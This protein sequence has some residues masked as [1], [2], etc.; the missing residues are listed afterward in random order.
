MSENLIIDIADVITSLIEE[1]LIKKSDTIE[2]IASLVRTRSTKT[3]D[4][5]YISESDIKSAMKEYKEI[6]NKS[7]K[8]NT[9]TKPSEETLENQSQLQDKYNKQIQI[10]ILLT[11]LYKNGEFTLDQTMGNIYNLIKED[12]KELG[13]N[14][15]EAK[16]IIVSLFSEL[17]NDESN[18][19]SKYESAQEE[20]DDEQEDK[21]DEEEGKKKAS[22]SISKI[23]KMANIEMRLKYSGMGSLTEKEKK[24]K[25]TKRKTKNS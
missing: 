19:L 8:N 7:F 3:A 11:R 2:K 20:E 5:T 24:E 15:G 25:K 10:K 6:I 1:G 17:S 21:D 12:S 16:N 18:T 23:R 9:D 13:I 4:L 22:D 14:K